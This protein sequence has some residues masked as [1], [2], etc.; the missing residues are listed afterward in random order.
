MSPL[1]SASSAGGTGGEKKL[2]NDSVGRA[3]RTRRVRLVSMVGISVTARLRRVKGRTLIPLFLNLVL[4]R[5]VPLLLPLD[6]STNCPVVNKI[7]RVSDF[8]LINVRFLE[9]LVLEEFVG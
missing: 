6:F 4:L 5:Q 1:S 2:K 8:F 7:A 9:D 3:L